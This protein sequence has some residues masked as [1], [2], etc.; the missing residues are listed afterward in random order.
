MF[1]KKAA[2]GPN[3][4]PAKGKPPV[5]AKGKAKAAP[6]KGPPPQWSQIGNQ[7]LAGKGGKPG[8]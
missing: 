1:Q 5:K 6:T 4:P 7:M 3:Q 8:C 2:A